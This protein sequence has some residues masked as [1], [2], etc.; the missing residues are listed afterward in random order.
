MR[1]KF[2]TTITDDMIAHTLV[3]IIHAKRYDDIPQHEHLIR[4]AHLA[5]WMNYLKCWLGPTLTF[6]DNDDFDGHHRTRAAWYIARRCGYQ[7]QIP[8]RLQLEV[9]L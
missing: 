9:E 6:F 1:T 3:G 2:D 5:W 8:V 4:I 7:I